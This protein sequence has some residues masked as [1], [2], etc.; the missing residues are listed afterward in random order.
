MA[1]LVGQLSIQRSGYFGFT[2]AVTLLLATVCHPMLAQ[3]TAVPLRADVRGVVVDVVVTDGQGRPVTGLTRDDF[4]VEE[5]K[6]PQPV[7]FFDVHG[8]APVTDFVAPKIPRLPP[9]TFLNLAKAPGFGTPTVILY[10][11]LNTPLTQQA[12]GHQQVLS[13][14][15]HRRPG[16]QIAIFVLTDKLHLLQGFTEDTDLLAAALSSKAG[17]P[18]TTTLLRPSTTLASTPMTGNPPLPNGHDPEEIF[19]ALVDGAR[20]MVVGIRPSFRISA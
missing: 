6:V 20:E 19:N 1:A 5:D 12:F 3:G 11:A 14:I 15:R 18:Q 9:N 2:A 13:L 4:G 10:D 8:V 7:R 17:S 16:T